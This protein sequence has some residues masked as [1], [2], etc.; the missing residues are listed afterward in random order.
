[1]KAKILSIGK[2]IY[3]GNIQAIM[4]PGFNGK[5]EIL[6]GHADAFFLLKSGDVTLNDEKSKIT[7]I[8]INGGLCKI[9]QKEIL[10]LIR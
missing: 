9:I 7:K 1:M 4:L 5:I 8:P 10:V 3:N 2:P 6:E